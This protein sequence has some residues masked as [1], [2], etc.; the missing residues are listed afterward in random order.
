MVVEAS[1][2]S[3]RGQHSRQHSG[4]VTQ[5]PV[6]TKPEEWKKGDLNVRIGSH[7]F[8]EGEQIAAGWPSWLTSVAS[9]AIH[10]LVPL[11]TDAFEKLDKVFLFCL[12]HP[13]P[14]STFMHEFPKV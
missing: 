12:S 13:S 6:D 9:E 8:A 14:F 11:K 2:H 1:A 4:V 10:G 5:H 3:S 7:R